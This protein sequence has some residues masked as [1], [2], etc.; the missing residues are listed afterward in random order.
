MVSKLVIDTKKQLVSLNK[1]DLFFIASVIFSYLFVIYALLQNIKSNIDTGERVPIGI[2]LVKKNIAERKLHRQ[3]FWQPLSN[4]F[5]VFNRDFIRTEKLSSAKI[6]LNDKSEILL[7]E[8]TLIYLEAQEKKVSLNLRGGNL[9]VD[10]TSADSEKEGSQLNIKTKDS[11]L[12]VGKA[13]LEMGF[14]ENTDASSFT[15]L[16]LKKG[17]PQ[18]LTK[19]GKTI[20]IKNGESL[21]IHSNN[22][23][24]N[25]SKVK[26]IEPVDSFKKEIL[27]KKEDVYF[28]WKITDKLLTPYFQ[29]SEEQDFKKILKSTVVNKQGNLKLSLGEGTYY[30][31]IRYIH[32]ITKKE[33]YSFTNRLNLIFID[34]AVNFQ[35]ASYQGNIGQEASTN[36][37]DTNQANPEG[38]TLINFNWQGL[39]DASSYQI[40]I[41]TTPDFKDI[42]ETRTLFKTSASFYLSP[43]KYYYRVKANV[44]NMANPIISETSAV[45]VKPLEKNEKSK[46]DNVVVLEAGEA[47]NK[48][49]TS[50]DETIDLNAL[51]KTQKEIVAKIEEVKKEK[52]PP[53]KLLKP[54]NKTKLERKELTQKNKGL[55]FSW[56]TEPNIPFY[57]FQIS[58]NKK[59]ITSIVD[60]TSSKNDYHFNKDIEA[61]TYYWRVIGKNKSENL[62]SS[63]IYTFIIKKL[64]NIKIIY[65][66]DDLVIEQ[67]SGELKYSWEKVL[68]KGEYS[69]EL[70]EDKYFKKP[71]HKAKVSEEEYEYDLPKVPEKYYYWR[72]KLID[73]DKVLAESPVHS[74]RLER[75][76]TV[77]EKIDGSTIKG[78]VKEI[79]NG[80]V[81]IVDNKKTIKLPIKEIK[82]IMTN[83][84]Y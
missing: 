8:N 22:K 6:I 70:A 3:E 41:S 66:N 62:S 19:E 38:K 50:K 21:Q 9:A 72:V 67:S 55:D 25:D 30:W 17:E 28:K 16:Q 45:V 32:P 26:L 23:E 12:D 75:A 37:N 69:F 71:L 43:K 61:G 56:T 84:K 73:K 78:V 65:P 15:S 42:K 52:F 49:L 5:P 27:S 51:A 20:E 77:I 2:L 54:S 10:R 4:Q 13:S 29:I 76:F 60:E 63:P 53:I 33:N 74:Y 36:T 46:N 7:E 1:G 34:K 79:K 82:E 47:L 57:Q 18:I 58:N 11:K 59:M 68:D 81:V 14:V 35:L 64:S 44:V 40:E 48:V 31:R 83:K 24:I 39:E 80:R